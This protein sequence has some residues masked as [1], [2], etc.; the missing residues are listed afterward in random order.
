M[1]KTI[2]MCIFLLSYKG[3]NTSANNREKS[4]SRIKKS[5]LMERDNVLLKCAGVEQAILSMVWYYYLRLLPYPAQVTGPIL[6]KK[7][8]VLEDRIHSVDTFALNKA[9][10][11]YE[12]NTSK[13]NIESLHVFVKTFG[14]FFWHV[15]LNFFF[16]INVM[17][18][19][20][21]MR[22]KIF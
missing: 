8:L 22:P 9:G 19:L 14:H 15:A 17:F 1:D 13:K 18:I 3:L 10:K 16:K 11:E 7:D 20:S 6:L 12:V 5:M 21:I 2:G 4:I